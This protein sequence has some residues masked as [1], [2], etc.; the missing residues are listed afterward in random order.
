MRLFCRISEMKPKIITLTLNP[1]YD[2]HCE[3]ESF[4]PFHENY[5]KRVQTE[6]GGKG[7]N[8]ILQRGGE[9]D[10]GRDILGTVGAVAFYGGQDHPVEG[11][12]H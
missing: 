7:V 3:V 2:V 10:E 12:Q 4:R 8:I 9:G 6:A 5:V 11:E 1:A